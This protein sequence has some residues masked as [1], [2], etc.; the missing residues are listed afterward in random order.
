M[1]KSKTTR[2]FDIIKF[3]DWYGEN[4]SVQKSSLF[5]EDCIWLGI[6]DA[7]PQIMASQAKLFGVETEETTGWVSY[8][9]PKEVLMTTRMHLNRNQV[10]KL[11]PIL[12]KFVDT[13][14]IE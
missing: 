10:S 8:P 2:G 14:E 4:C 9:V 12:Q 11:L 3:K 1:E 5:E 6:N 7:N 13:G